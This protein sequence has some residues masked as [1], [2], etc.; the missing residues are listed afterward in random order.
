M[1]VRSVRYC[2]EVGLGSGEARP[3]AVAQTEP[4]WRPSFSFA[5]PVIARSSS[6]F[7]V[8]TSG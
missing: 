1:K 2:N 3:R 8:R 7:E 5:S 4:E 6:S